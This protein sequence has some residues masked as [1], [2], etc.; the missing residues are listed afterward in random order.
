MTERESMNI[1]AFA[2][3]KGG[4]GKSTLTAHLAAHVAA[5]SRVMLIDA[6]VQ[7]SLSLWHAARL[8][9]DLALRRGSAGI[10]RIVKTAQREGY[11]WVFIDTPANTS[12]IVSQAIQAATLVVVPTG[13]GVFDLSAVKETLDFSHEL[14]KPCAL[15]LNGL[16]SRP[17]LTESIYLREVDSVIARCKIPIWSYQIANRL[18]YQLALADGVGVTEYDPRCEAT[19]EIFDLWSAIEAAVR[20]IN[21]GEDVSARRVAA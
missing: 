21:G 1:I 17:N 6:D 2:S 18:A 4:T 14:E 7:G 19:A 11:D 10:K 8:S 15:I 13:V 5:S 20:V 12:S 16:S 9:G 3:C